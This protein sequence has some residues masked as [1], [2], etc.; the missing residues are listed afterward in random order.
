MPRVTQYSLNGG[1][2]DDTLDART[3]NDDVEA[4]GGVISGNGGNDTLIGG[5]GK[6]VMKGGDG[7][8]LLVA[9]LTDLEGIKAGTVVYDGG[10]GSDTLDLSGIPFADGTGIWV[11]MDIAGKGSSNI[12][13]DVTFNHDGL[14][15]DPTYSGSSFS[16]NFK[17]IEN[18]ILGGGDD[19]VQLRTSWPSSVFGGDGDDNIATGSGND[20]IDGGSG[21]DILNGGWGS[22]TLK[23][24]GGNDSFAITGRVVNQY[25]HDVIVDFETRTDVADTSYDEIW[26]W[27]GWSIQ[28]DEGDPTDPL[29]GYLYD[30][31]TLFGEVTLTGLTLADADDVEVFNIDPSTGKPDYS[32]I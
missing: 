14:A 13:T 18:F 1:R 25:T 5:I 6:D 8:D 9:S 28:W 23:G 3:L 19:L 31:G 15:E 16:N 27:Q 22:D 11:T 2:G 29:H 24:G 17:G 26:L 32:V 30:N 12:R 10:Q 21:N 7:D 20:Y 4:A